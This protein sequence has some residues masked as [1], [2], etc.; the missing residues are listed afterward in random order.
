MKTFKHYQPES[1]EAAAAVLREHRGRAKP[2]AGG[3]DLLGAL[4]DRVHPEYPEAIVNLKAIP[5]L[6][7][8]RET[9]AGLSIGALAR[10]ADIENHPAVKERYPLL[11]QAA[12]AVASPQIRNMA[13]IGGNICQEP[14]CWY[15]RH[16][17]NTFHCLRKDGRVCNA[18]T[19]ENRYHSIF[20]AAHVADPPCT[21]DCPAQTDIPGYMEKLRAGDVAGAAAILHQVNPLPAV[22]G[23]VCPHFCQGDC[24]RGRLDEP[25]SI[26]GVERFLGDYIL[27]HPAEFALKAPP[28]TGG[29]AAVVGSGPAGL[30]AAHYLRRAGHEVVV[31]DRLKEPGGMLTQAIPEYRLPKAK[32]QPAIRALE[33]AGV[34][35]RLGVEIG[36]DLTLGELEADFDAVFLAVGAWSTPRIGVPGE[37]SALS[38]LDFLGRVKNGEKVDLGVKVLV[39]GGGNVAVDAA[40]TA[41]RLGAGKVTMACL[42]RR[43]EMPAWDWEVAQAVEEGVEILPSWGPKRLLTAAG[44]ISGVELMRCTSVFNDQGRFAPTYDETVITFLE[45]DQVILAVGQRVD[46]SGLDRDGTL[47]AGRGRLETDPRT[48]ATERPKV[49]AGGDMVTGPA[50]VIEALAAGRR[51]AEA[52]DRFMRGVPETAALQAPPR[53]GLKSLN[54]ARLE[55]T[56]AAP[57]PEQP[58]GRRRLETE[59]AL[60]YSREAALSEA[61][62]CFN[63][64]CVAVSPSDIGLALTAL[65]AQ[66]RTTKRTIP[67]GDFFTARVGRSTVIEDDELVLEILVPAPRPGQYQAFKKFRLRKAIDFPIAGVAV[68]YGLEDG[69]A[70]DARI[71]LGAAAPAPLRAVAAEA[72]LNGRVPDEATA[73]AAARAAVEGTMAL[74]CNA[75]KVQI[76]QALVKRAIIG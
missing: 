35:F 59:D 25:V 32:V 18:L 75:F 16:P 37:E 20:G 60:G 33:T 74:G 7:D 28:A 12:Q 66:I 1:V 17:D 14:R 22:T 34:Q 9:P 63:C 45:A 71:V 3:T 52:M 27:E 19:G 21:A 26:R 51:A 47:T 23:R 67:A 11:A 48:Q 46:L 10:L 76:F 72:V 30:A 65:D 40:L 53:P 36:R 54:T 42:E 56:P 29:K 57:L 70:V 43:E 2:L 13:T 58:V 6:A 8:I 73:A 31:F 61:D 62:R 24:N 39:I 5:G 68:V 44:R 38:A 64:G 49:F 41:V 50:T 15:Y 4:K 69:R 55:P